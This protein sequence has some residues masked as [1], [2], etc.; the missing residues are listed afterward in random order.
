VADS[1]DAMTSDRPYRLARPVELAL[2]EIE[3]GSGTQFDPKVVD[4]FISLVEEESLT[5]SEGD[6]PD[7]LAHVG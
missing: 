2:E 6:D 4:A 7:R 1:F 5:G 3:D